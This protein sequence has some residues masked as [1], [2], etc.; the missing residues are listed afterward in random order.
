MES[1]TPLSELPSVPFRA[2]E[3][4]KNKNQANK[5]PSAIL[6]LPRANPTREHLTSEQLVQAKEEL[7]NKQNL[8][9]EY[10]RT[11]TTRIDPRIPGQ[12]LGLITFI[13]AKNAIPDK[14]GCYGVLKLRG[15]FDNEYEADCWGDK[16]IREVDSLSEIEYVYVGVEIPLLKDNTMYTA[17]TREV[18]IQKKIDE[19][20]KAQYKQKKEEERKQ[21]LDIQERRNKLTDTSLRHEEENSIDDLDMYIQL[22]VKKANALKMIDDSNKA[23][24]QSNHILSE[25]DPKIQDLE[26]KNPSFKDEYLE[27]YNRAL[28]AIGA[29]P[30]DNDIVKY[31]TKN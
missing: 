15:N 12:R 24:S 7:I 29:N 2:D 11:R 17:S 6:E 5:I 31:M 20:V 10:P 4:Y 28:T 14:E 23:I 26:E 1:N 27:R 22:K 13:P 3:E 8:K 18:D 30:G 25:T 16:L 21:M 19:T 9:M